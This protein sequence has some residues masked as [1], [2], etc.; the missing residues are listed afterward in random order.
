MRIKNRIDKLEFVL[1]SQKK[2]RPI[3][4]GLDGK[5]N[6]PNQIK[7]Q[8][9]RMW[10]RLESEADDDFIQRAYSEH[11]GRYVFLTFIYD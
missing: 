1:S 9:G 8:D 3:T 4:V 7:G 2:G 5:D 6:V 11:G 10:R